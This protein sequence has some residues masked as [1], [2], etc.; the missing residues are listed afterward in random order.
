MP[1]RNKTE[2]LKREAFLAAFSECGNVSVACKASKVGRTTVYQW[3]KEPAFIESFHEMEGRAV[4]VLED[5]AV[6]RAVNGVSRPVLYQGKPVKING[7]NLIEYEYSDTLLI[8]LL[9]G[10]RPGRYRDQVQHVGEGGGPI[11]II[12][13][14]AGFQD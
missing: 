12:V 6:R 10:L 9:K 5:E 8:F 1:K 14:D 2:Q 13:H 11:E 3:L 7:K 4:K